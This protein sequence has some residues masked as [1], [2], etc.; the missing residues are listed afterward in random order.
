MGQGDETAPLLT[1]ARVAVAAQKDAGAG[2][3]SRDH[4]TAMI[5]FEQFCNRFMR[6][7]IRG[8]SVLV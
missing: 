8:P 5:R 3:P 1:N 2:G 7:F 6:D 4:Q